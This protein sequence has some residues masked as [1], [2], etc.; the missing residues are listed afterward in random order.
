MLFRE[1]QDILINSRVENIND[2]LKDNL[3]LIKNN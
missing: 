2:D 3:A 1:E